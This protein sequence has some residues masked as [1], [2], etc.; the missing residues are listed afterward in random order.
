MFIGFIKP[1]TELSPM[2]KSSDIKWHKVTWVEQKLV[3]AFRR[4]KIK[5]KTNWTH[6]TTKTV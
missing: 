6:S 1:K 3:A 4:G 2:L 5:T